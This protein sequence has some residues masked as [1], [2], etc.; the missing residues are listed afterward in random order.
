[1]QKIRTKF[2]ERQR[3]PRGHRSLKRRCSADKFGII[4]LDELSYVSPCTKPSRASRTRTP[5]PN[6]A[7]G[8]TFQMKAKEQG[9]LCSDMRLMSSAPLSA[10]ITRETL[11]TLDPIVL[12]AE[13]SLR[14]DLNYMTDVYFTID[15]AP[16]DGGTTQRRNDYWRALQLELHLDLNT[17]GS[18]VVSKASR[19]AR[20]SLSRHPRAGVMTTC[21]RFPTLIRDLRELLTSLAPICQSEQIR[22]I[23]DAE[24]ICQQV[25][26]GCCNFV[27]LS[28]DMWTI[29]REICLS[30]N[31]EKLVKRFWQRREAVAQSS[32]ETIDF[33]VRSIK[34]LLV[35]IEMIAMVRSNAC[36]MPHKLHLLIILQANA[37]EHF[38]QNRDVLLSN[39]IQFEQ[40]NVQEDL[41]ATISSQDW[42][43]T[44]NNHQ[45]TSGGLFDTFTGKFIDLVVAPELDLPTALFLEHKRVQQLRSVFQKTIYRRAC[46][47]TLRQLTKYLSRQAAIR[48]HSIRNFK[49]NLDAILADSTS[50]SKGYG[51]VQ[52]SVVLEL[53][54]EAYTLSEYHSQ[55]RIPTDS[56][57]CLATCLLKS[58]LDTSTPSHKT[59]YNMLVTRFLDMVRAEIKELIPLNTLQIANRYRYHSRHQDCEV[60]H[61]RFSLDEDGEDFVVAKMAH[62]ATLHWRT[63]GPLVYLRND[64]DSSQAPVG[65]TNINSETPSSTTEGKDAAG[66]QL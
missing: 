24:L 38:K 56:H 32:E 44:C 39:Y 23:L 1:M 63:W 54:R 66:P 21:R 2:M 55:S 40:A 45:R 58:Y 51:D 65:I 14:H 46:Y 22:D 11:S 35:C 42:M 9:S 29:V 57:L 7:I 18:R 36:P 8:T 4:D 31:N 34:E 64:C 13:R 10:P 26:H 52:D 5:V 48:D 12:S 6:S 19:K 37:G 20:A 28:H 30:N 33:L 49:R 50:G 41:G 47:A 25:C 27:K 62:M 61:Q 60:S 3:S 16:P 15:M 43:N 17:A 53:V 59:L